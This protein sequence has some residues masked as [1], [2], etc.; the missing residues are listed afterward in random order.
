MEQTLLQSIVSPT[1]VTATLLSNIVFVAFVLSYV[2]SEKVRN[3][4]KDF[5]RKNITLALFVISATAFLGSMLY[6]N[7]VG[8]PPCELC[9]WARIF[10][11]PQVFVAGVALWKKDKAGTVVDY[12]LPLTLLGTLLTLYHSFI[13]WGGKSIIP[14]TQEGAA[15]SKLYVMEYGYITIP[16]MALSCFLYLLTASIIYKKAK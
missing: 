6:S 13:L 16:V 2:S 15:C 7:V 10:M 11:Y 5:L 12:L 9:W 3:L 1:I 4:S 14:C 8:Y